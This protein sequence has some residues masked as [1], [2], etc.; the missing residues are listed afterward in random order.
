MKILFTCGGT[1]GHVN[2]AVA[3]AQMFQTRNPG[4][5]V[6]FVGADRGMET[7]LV[8]KEGYPIETVTI[9]SF[10]RS[11]TPAAVGH[12][13]KTLLNMNKSRRQADAILDRFRPDLVVGTGG[14]ASYPVVHAAAARGIPTAV[15][16]SNAVP[17]LTTKTLSK[18]VDVVMVGFEESRNHYDD[19]SKV[20]VTGTP[21]REDFFRYTRKEARAK[22]GLTDDK[23]LVV[24][25]WGSLGASVMNQ[26]ITRCITLE[27]GEGN[28]FRHIHGAGRNYREVLDILEKVGVDLKAH[29]Q[30]DVRQYIYDMPLVMAAADLVLCRAGASTI[31]EV[32]AIARPAVLVP[33]PNVVADHQTKNASVLA[34]AG[35]AVLLPESQSSGETLY[36]LVKELLAD[37]A[38]RENMSRALRQMGSPDAAERIYQTLVALLEKKQK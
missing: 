8:P 31:A 25:V 7:K 34:N 32:T 2:P 14:Y 26:Q 11:L 9:T 4:C 6:L 36:A 10:R 21:V 3:L 16:E 17:G 1:A 22:L 37:P 33:S 28:P 23:P 35:G 38:R 24:S 15:H 19:P 30:V 13:I 27:C 18:V 20:V 12:N 29:P 5:E